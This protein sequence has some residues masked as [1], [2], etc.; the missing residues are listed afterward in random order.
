[1]D[2]QNAKYILFFQTFRSSAKKLPMSGKPNQKRGACTG[3]HL[4][5]PI[6]KTNYLK[7]VFPMRNL[8]RNKRITLLQALLMVMALMWGCKKEFTIGNSESNPS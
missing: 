4:G 2:V 5:I 1:M 8:L 7:N 6:L 3:I